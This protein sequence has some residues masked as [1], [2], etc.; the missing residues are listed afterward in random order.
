MNAVKFLKPRLLLALWAFPGHL[1]AQSNDVWT[2]QYNHTIFEADDRLTWYGT[3]VYDNQ[4]YDHITYRSRA[5][6]WYRAGKNHWRFNFNRSHYFEWHDDFGRRRQEKVA[7]IGFSSGIQRGYWRG[8]HG[9]FE[10]L[11]FRL[12]NLVGVPSPLTSF[13]QFRVVDGEGGKFG[14]VRVTN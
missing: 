8:E 11:T 13:V 10:A 2:S 14:P 3:L 1:G 7:R 12:F 9:L 4:V 5:G 6:E